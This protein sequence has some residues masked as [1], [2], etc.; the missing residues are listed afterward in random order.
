MAERKLGM[1]MMLEERPA[2][3]VVDDTSDLLP[4]LGEMLDSAY[5][6]TFATG[7]S[8]LEQAGGPPPSLILLNLNMT[9]ADGFT[10]S[11]KMKELAGWRDVPVLVLIDRDDPGMAERAF[12]AG[13]A[14][15]ITKP[16]GT[17][18]VRS[19]VHT[20]MSL[21]RSEEQLEK[22]ARYLEAEAAKRTREISRIQEIAIMSMAALAEMRDTE[23]GNHI[24]RTKLYVGEL[25]RQ[26]SRTDKYAD[27]LTPE[28]IKLIVS[29]SPLHDIGKIGI[30]D[31]ILLKPGPLT[32]EEYEIM[33]THTALGH[34]AILR[35]EEQLDGS[36]SFLGYAKHIIYSHHE[37]W[38]GSGYPEG[39]SGER[40]PLAAR[41]MAVADVYD[42]L[43]SK[44]VYKDAL[45]HESAAAIII[46]DA[47]RHFDPD[48]VAVF[49]KCQH[50]LADIAHKY[51]MSEPEPLALLAL[52][53]KAL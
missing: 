14:D 29:S 37:K 33:K 22:Q 36:E 46:G 15:Y 32:R 27:V 16:I 6:L 18:T 39:L 28:A 17:V 1:M 26:L 2:I 51:R 21:R 45:S 31:H 40:I 20:H 34:D 50:R 48:I 7:K 23:T 53:P 3:L 30:P 5:D 12:E 9:E 38:D 49:V 24:R 8:M 44:R 19:R 10:V 13:A 35:A 52:C 11:R 41:L 42:A 4:P 47:G 43:T 25:A